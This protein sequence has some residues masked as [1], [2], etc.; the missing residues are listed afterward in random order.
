MPFI[1]KTLFFVIKA[2]EEVYKWD[3]PVLQLIKNL[4]GK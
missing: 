4:C 2:K 3:F 1:D